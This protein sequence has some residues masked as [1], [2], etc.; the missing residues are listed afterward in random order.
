MLLLA[1]EAGVPVEY[2]TPALDEVRLAEEMFLTGSVKEILPI[3][4]VGGLAL[5]A[6]HPGP[7]TRKMRDLFFRNRDLWLE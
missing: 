2:R 1:A 6:S 7:V 3:H 4:H 5:A